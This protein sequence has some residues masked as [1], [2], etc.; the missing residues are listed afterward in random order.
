M[1]SGSNLLIAAAA[2]LISFVILLGA[3]HF[4]GISEWWTVRS[5]G[6]GPSADSTRLVDATY[7]VYVACAGSATTQISILAAGLAGIV[8][9]LT[10]KSKAK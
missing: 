2:G 5:C 3:S 6:A 9:W 4:L 8:G 10:L 7:R 1:P